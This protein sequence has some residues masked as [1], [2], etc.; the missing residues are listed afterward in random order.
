MPY[1]LFLTKNVLFGYFWARIIEKTITLFEI[2]ALKCVY[3]QNFVKN[4]K[5]LNLGA[6]FPVCGIS[7]LEFVYLQTFAEKQKLLNLGPR[8]LYL[9]I[10]AL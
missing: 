7:G 1:W 3:L 4:K 6:K 10:F 8:M 9:G 2:A 5:Y